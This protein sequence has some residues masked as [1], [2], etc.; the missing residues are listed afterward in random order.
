MS[1]FKDTFTKEVQ[2]QLKVRQDAIFNRTPQSIQYYNSRNS[3]IRMTSSVNVAESNELAKKY[4]LLGG[5]LNENSKLRSGVGKGAEAY[6]TTTPS[7]GTNYRGIKPMPGITGLDIKSKSAYGS[8][9]EVTVNFQCWD[10]RQLEDLELLYMRPG[11]TVLIEWGWLPYIDNN[12]KLQ[13]NLPQFYD[14]LDKQATDR[15]IIFKELFD[16]SKKSGVNYDAMYGYIKNYQWS[17]RPD[18]G[19]DC[20]TSVITTGEIIESLKVNYVRS[21]IDTSV[22]GLLN[23][24]LAKGAE[25]NKS[26]QYNKYYGKNILAGLWSE[27]YKLV[28]NLENFTFISGSSLSR[29]IR[30][31]PFYTT[32]TNNTDNPDSI[33]SNGIQC[34]MPLD[35]VIDIINQYVIPENAAPTTGS[36]LSVSLNKSTVHDDGSDLLCI[37]HPIQVSADPTVCL[38]KSPL[39]YEGDLLNPAEEAASN[40]ELADA[41]T[42]ATL[43]YN[44]LK[45]GD[46]GKVGRY[47]GDINSPSYKKFKSG[48]KRIK[49]VAI[50]SI[51]NGLLEKDGK[52]N[53]ESFLKSNIA[54]YSVNASSNADAL[55]FL[56][57]IEGDFNKISL[58][59]KLSYETYFEP[60]VVGIAATLQQIEVLKVDTIKITGALATSTSTTATSIVK[61]A[62]QA[63]SRLEFLKTLPRNYFYNDNQYDELGVIKNIYV[64]LNYLYKLSLDLNLESKDGKEKSEI[65]IYNY[66]KTLMLD[67]QTSIGNINSFEIHVDPTDSIARI[68]DVNYTGPKVQGANGTYNSLFPLEIHNTKSV[69]R[70]YSLQSQIFPEQSA[71][72]AIG[73]QAKGGQLG[74]QNNTM[75][76]FNRSLIDRI[77]P[78]KDPP[79]T[80]NLYSGNQGLSQLRNGLTVLVQL[81]ST[82]GQKPPV[83][84][85]ST[86]DA[87]ISYNDGKNALRD[88]IVYF[89]SLTSS[90]SKNRNL[91]PIKFSCEMDG[92]GGLVI[93]HM[94]RLPDHVLPRGYRGEKGVGA[95][96]GQTITSI[97]HTI[98][99][100]DWVTKIDALNIVLNDDKTLP[101]FKN[102]DLKVVLAPVFSVE[103]GAAPVNL[104]QKISSFGKVDPAV[105]VEARPFLDMIA[106]AEG[107]AGAGQNGYDIT[108]G[109]GRISG[110]NETY[111]GGHPQTPIFIPG[112]GNTN[113]AGRYQFLDSI[114]NPTWKTYGKDY[115]YTFNKKGQDL[116]GYNL[117]T[118]KRKGNPFLKEAYDI[119]KQQITSNNIN[120]NNNKAFL[121][122]LDIMSYEWASLPDSRGNARYSSQGG[123]YSPSSIYK[124]FIEAVKKY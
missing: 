36:I 90:P 45:E 22:T 122:L 61:G 15:T 103:E 93:G 95:Q 82:F 12:N 7:G 17:A 57:E 78:K 65:N 59:L 98:N 62:K 86:T 31:T 21:D 60:K 39:W 38:I 77:I 118:V 88:I 40:K 49:S 52:G 69:V 107:T 89:Q 43:A 96:L 5:T 105:P 55:K 48:F 87:N 63:L 19:Y 30:V 56:R 27:S 67:I 2:D 18:G 37:A 94:F 1:I 123:K 42:E 104:E 54:S 28:S 80:D 101:E 6:S 113:A 74:I 71:I 50:Y 44:D 25:L 114:A 70:N 106:F 84:S 34:Y 29:S 73:S 99:N 3:W 53:L 110:W 20:Q 11:Y 26:D 97:S 75:I 102:L 41:T 33:I 115:K 91:I 116:A 124:V 79:I 117:L 64:N 112:I 85:S 16:K 76:D 109:F 66:L 68:I 4:V 120:V 121:N 24:Q 108:V 72:I 9:R 14:I 81:F 100:N 58:D 51:L 13:T 23:D 35:A 47:F 92:I 83:D 32:E 8:L 46:L 10:I 111:S 119:A